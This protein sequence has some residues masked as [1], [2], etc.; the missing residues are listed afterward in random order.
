M[1]FES[2]KYTIN[3]MN[4]SLMDNAV[5]FADDVS[6]ES[7]SLLRV[8]ERNCSE[9]YTMGVFPCQEIRFILRRQLGYFIIQVCE[10]GQLDLFVL[11]GRI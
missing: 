1:Q 7:F 11:F 8:K 9:T 6:F 10:K 3:S 5:Q 2:F 4:L